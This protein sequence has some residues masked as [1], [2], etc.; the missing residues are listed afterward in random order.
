M[1]IIL[2]SDICH[3]I[4]GGTVYNTKLVE[5]LKTKHQQVAVEVA[6]DINSYDFNNGAT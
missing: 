6:E 2:T 1:I 3:K 5:F 4:S